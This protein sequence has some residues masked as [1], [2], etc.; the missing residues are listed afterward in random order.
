MRKVVS[1]L[2]VMDYLAILRRRKWETLACLVIGLVGA[3]AVFVAMPKTYRSSTLILV[4]SQKVPIELIKPVTVDTIE[5]RLISIQQ[6]ILSRTLLQRI[7]EEFGLYKSQLES[8]PLENVIEDMRKRIKVDTVENRNRRNTQ[9]FTIAYEGERPTLVMQVTNKLGAL[10]I[11]E[12]LKV[13]EQLVEGASEFFEQELQGLREKLD[14]QEKQISEFKQKYMGQ[15]PEQMEANMRKL[16][17]LQMEVQSANDAVR[18]AEEKREILLDAIKH[19]GT[20]MIPGVSGSPSAQSPQGRLQQLRAYLMQLQSEYK[21]TYPDVIQT[22]RQ[23]QELEA[24]LGGATHTQNSQDG[25]GS[26]TSETD[27][28][29][30]SASPQDYSE[31]GLLAQVRAIETEIGI[32]KNRRAA[33]EKQ[34]KLFERRVELAPIHEQEMSLLLRDYESQRRNYEN[35]LGKKVTAKI[36]ESMEKRQ[37]GEQFRIIDPANLPGKPVKPDPLRIFLG[38]G[39][40]GLALAGGL[41]WWK[42]LRNVPFRRPEEVEAALELPTLASIP[43]MSGLA[44]G[45]EPPQGEADPPKRKWWLRWLAFPKD[46]ALRWSARGPLASWKKKLLPEKKTPA[47][48]QAARNA[49]A[50]EQFRVLAGRIIQMR[51][52]KGVRVLA[53]TSSLPGEGKSTLA[54][55]LAVTLARDYLEHTILMDGDMRNPSISARL[56]L[57]EEKGLMNV[58]TGECDL[59]SVLFQHAHPNLKV[60]TAGTSQVDRLGLPATRLQVQKLIDDLRHRGVFVILDGPP[61]LPMADMNLYSEIVDGMLMVVRSGQ[62]PQQIVIE[63]LDFLASGNVEGVVLNGAMDLGRT[64]YATYTTSRYGFLEQSSLLYLPANGGKP[65]I[66]EETSAQGG[67]G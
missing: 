43:Y 67:R 56:G 22:K 21:E 19:P 47:A 20:M 23:I 17:R 57:D 38:G 33:A 32:R 36:S 62:T 61:I 63:A 25:S 28:T 44:S 7:I 6:Q 48:I 52:K 51:E 27:G 49:L 4:E 53:I 34:I 13:R 46:L 3:A 15:L 18:M 9:A 31:K 14:I 45:A 12:N 5:E 54:I 8:D 2:E 65:G 24:Q 59:E 30:L 55:G 29:S 58:L 66:P 26:A 60:L 1:M 41:I 11:E 42:D 40:A 10:F 50:A 64:Y 37:K 39:A 35:L 16:D